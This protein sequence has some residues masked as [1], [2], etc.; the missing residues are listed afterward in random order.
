VA[1]GVTKNSGN[2][3]FRVWIREDAGETQF[4]KLVGASAHQRRKDV[5][6][7]VRASSTLSPSAWRALVKTSWAPRLHMPRRRDASTK[8]LRRNIR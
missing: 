3:T 6:A 7:V 8:R 2:Y 5:P 1:T 4:E